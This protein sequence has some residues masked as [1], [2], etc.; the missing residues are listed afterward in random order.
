MV[1]ISTAPQLVDG[2]R[3]P[4]H[5]GDKCQ[6]PCPAIRVAMPPG[7]AAAFSGA[8]RPEAV[9]LAT[10]VLSEARV[11]P[12]AVDRDDADGVRP[13]GERDDGVARCGLQS[14]R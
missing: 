2:A 7:M 1:G 10:D 3:G 14:R 9:T 11:F 8:E 13:A 6:R 12:G 5:T 4:S